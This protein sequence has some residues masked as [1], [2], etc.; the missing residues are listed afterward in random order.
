M[1]YIIKLNENN[2]EEN[3]IKR[4]I[5]LYLLENLVKSVI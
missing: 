2:N 3:N 5:E 1:E 4:N